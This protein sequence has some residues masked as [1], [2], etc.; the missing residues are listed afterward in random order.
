MKKIFWIAS[1]P[2]SGNTWIRSII[3]SLFFTDEG[4][5]NF[6]H[7][8]Y[9]PYF[10]KK[11]NYEFIKEINLED[12]NNLNQIINISKYW[13][14]AQKLIKIQ[15][16]NFGFFKTHYA[17]V[18]IGNKYHYANKDVTH[19]VILIIRDPRDVAVSFAKHLNYS[20]EKTTKILV[21]NKAVIK[22]N[23]DTFPMMHLNWE[24]FYLSWMSLNIPILTIK[25][26][27]MIG[28]IHASLV[29]IINFFHENFN[30]K[31]N[32]KEIKIK[33]IIESTSF[34][35]MQ[36]MEKNDGFNEATYGSFFRK[37]KAQQWKSILTKDQIKI[38][39]NEFKNLMYEFGYL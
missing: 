33:N 25:Y 27:D 18:T 8:K 36:K 21:N 3:A 31:I 28:D 1:Y 9:I 35:S 38:I 15:N 30:I 23:D 39:E 11:K 16:G 34:E 12:Y 2:K 29:K 14:E 22:G 32:N 37:G 4:K 17:N 7:L 5:F 13:Y 24:N 26:E 6:S 20:I 19:G 10:D